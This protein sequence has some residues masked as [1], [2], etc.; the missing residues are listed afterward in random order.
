[1]RGRISSPQLPPLEYAKYSLSCAASRQ[2]DVKP[3]C[4]LLQHIGKAYFHSPA[5]RRVFIELPPEDSTPGMCGLLEKSLYGNRDAALNW[6]EA[7][8]SALVEMGF[9]KG[10]ANPCNFVRKERGLETIV[11]G[12]YFLTIGSEDQLSWMNV[13]MAKKF[14][15]KRIMMG[16]KANHTKQ[17]RFLNRVV[18][19]ED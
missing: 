11:H 16:A 19:R 10:E 4:I 14:K 18:T 2:G 3:C 7:Y 5:T 6:S 8:T 12:D 1:M 9:M 17:A 13:E 15:V